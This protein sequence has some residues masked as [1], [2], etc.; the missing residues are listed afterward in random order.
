M[1]FPRVDSRTDRVC[2]AGRCPQARQTPQ[3][4]AAELCRVP[5]KHE[6][7]W[8]IGLYRTTW[9]G[10]RAFAK[11]ELRTIAA[12]LTGARPTSDQASRVKPSCPS[13]VMLVGVVTQ[14][15]TG[16]IAGKLQSQVVQRMV[17]DHTCD[18]SSLRLIDVMGCTAP[19]LA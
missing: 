2:R 4:V 5:V 18:V 7:L 16:T 12:K 3:Q 14:P 15:V 6:E 11:V 8:D 17:S 10:R 13:A 9:K 1:T 19:S